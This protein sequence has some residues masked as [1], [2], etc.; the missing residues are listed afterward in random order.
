MGFARSR[1]FILA[2]SFMIGATE[3]CKPLLLLDEADIFPHNNDELKNTINS[4]YRS[5]N[6]SVIRTIGEDF[7]PRIFNTFR[8]KAIAQIDSTR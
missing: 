6:S 4:G 8:L 1:L 3:R 2:L 7:E 5:F